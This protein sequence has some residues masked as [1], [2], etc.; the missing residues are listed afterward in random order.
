[1]LQSMVLLIV[2][3]VVPAEVQ[4]SVD[5]SSCGATRSLDDTIGLFS[6]RDVED[7]DVEDVMEFR[8]FFQQLGYSSGDQNWKTPE[9]WLEDDSEDSGTNY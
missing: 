6:D 5:G 2:R 4:L 1:M 9:D 3:L 8:D 7:R